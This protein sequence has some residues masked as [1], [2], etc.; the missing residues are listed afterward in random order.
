M[1]PRLTSPLFPIV[2]DKVVR[3]ARYVGLEHV[4]AVYDRRGTDRQ[5]ALTEASWVVCPTTRREDQ[6]VWV[7]DGAGPASA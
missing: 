6:V 1:L 3:R 4:L 5:R 2:L 7:F